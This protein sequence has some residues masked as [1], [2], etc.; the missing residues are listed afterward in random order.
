MHERELLRGKR[1]LSLSPPSLHFSG[2]RRCDVFHPTLLDAQ[3]RGGDSRTRDEVRLVGD[4]TLQRDR[5]C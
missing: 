5:G 1:D 3:A 2:R 4:F